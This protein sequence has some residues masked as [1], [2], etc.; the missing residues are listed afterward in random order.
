MTVCNIATAHS[1]LGCAVISAPSSR[2]KS[3]SPSTTS[4]QPLLYSPH[5]V[6]S[7]FIYTCIYI[8]ILF[9][10]SLFLTTLS[11]LLYFLSLFIIDNDEGYECWIYFF[12]F[13]FLII[14]IIIFYILFF[15]ATDYYASH[16]HFLHFYSNV[17]SPNCCLEAA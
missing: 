1:A 11:M 10:S 8:S 16:L 17:K 14:I 2:A 12:E 13:L 4:L 9:F 7:L 15:R 5:L 3:F 6:H